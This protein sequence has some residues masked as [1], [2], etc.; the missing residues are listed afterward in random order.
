MQVYQKNNLYFFQTLYGGRGGSECIIPV[1]CTGWGWCRWLLSAASVFIFYTLKSLCLTHFI[2]LNRKDGLS[3]TPLCQTLGPTYSKISCLLL[4]LRRKCQMRGLS[5]WW[6]P[7]NFFWEY[8]WHF[9]LY[10]AL[11][12]RLES[13]W[14]CWQL[15]L[16]NMLSA[17]RK[18]P[19]LLQLPCVPSLTHSL[20]AGKSK[21]LVTMRVHWDCTN[22]PLIQA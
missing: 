11:K 12:V 20:L 1:L 8:L 9:Q 21:P 15:L 13:Y 7:L 18:G 3:V 5:R 6:F 16:D 14:T 2:N 17:K 4:S 22:A 10:P 19:F